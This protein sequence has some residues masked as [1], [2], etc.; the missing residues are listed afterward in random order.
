MAGGRNSLPYEISVFGCAAISRVRSK[1]NFA[2]MLLLCMAA[3]SDKL[4]M[5]GD[6]F[7]GG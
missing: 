3:S 7:R 1:L 5:K 6:L 2:R 4:C